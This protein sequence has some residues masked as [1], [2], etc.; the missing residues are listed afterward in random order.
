MAM[1]SHCLQTPF[2]S[3]PKSGLLVFSGAFRCLRPLTPLGEIGLPTAAESLVERPNTPCTT[4]MNRLPI[5]F[6]TRVGNDF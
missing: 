3:A 6:L 1:C 2:Q 4:P 5:W